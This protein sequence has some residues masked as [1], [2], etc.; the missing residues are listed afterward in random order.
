[1]PAKSNYKL[2]VLFEHEVRAAA[3]ALMAFRELMTQGEVVDD[4]AYGK[5][6]HGQFRA[7][8]AALL[9][10]EEDNACLVLTRVKK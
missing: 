4:E 1:M 7:C 9:G 10:A 6:L 3:K 5:A 8:E 2:V